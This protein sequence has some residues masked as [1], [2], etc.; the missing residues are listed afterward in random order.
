[1]DISTMRNSGRLPQGKSAA[2]ESRYSTLI[3]YNVYAGR[4]C[5]CFH[6]PPNSDMDYLYRAY[7]I[8]LMRA[9]TQAELDTPLESQHNKLVLG[10]TLTNYSCAP[11]A[12]GD[13]TSGLSISGPTLYQLSHPHHRPLTDNSIFLS[14]GKRAATLL[15]HIRLQKQIRPRLTPSSLCGQGLC[16]HHVIFVRVGERKAIWEG[17]GFVSQLVQFN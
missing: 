12:D 15:R 8:I 7:V 10:K 2:T 3:T 16:K 5:S 11:E 9:F 6:N 13:R 4:V 17:S 14:L 1:M